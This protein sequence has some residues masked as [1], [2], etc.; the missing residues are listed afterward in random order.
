MA[1][2]KNERVQERGSVVDRLVRIVILTIVSFIVSIAAVSFAVHHMRL[3]FEG[4]FKSISD[5]KVNQVCDVAKICID[6]DDFTSPTV[7]SPLKYGSLLSLIMADTTSENLSAEGYGLFAYKD[8]QLSLLVSE[9]VGD[10]CAH[11]HF[12]LLLL[13]YF[14]RYCC[15]S[16][17][18]S[19]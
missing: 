9:G 11:A 6:G 8:G 10:T 15:L 5:K 18:A 13:F 16:G 4:E 1:N 17:R 14:V 12:V 2:L 7:N 3:Q 19:G